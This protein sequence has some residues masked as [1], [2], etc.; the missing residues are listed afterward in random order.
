MVF[1]HFSLLLF[2]SFIFFNNTKQFWFFTHNL[3]FLLYYL[4]ILG[5]CL[6]YLPI[7]FNIRCNN[8]LER[9]IYIG[10]SFHLF[11]Y[12][13][14]YYLH[15]FRC[16]VSNTILFC[17]VFFNGNFYLIRL[18]INHGHL[19]IIL[20]ILFLSFSISNNLHHQFFNLRLS[21]IVLSL[22]LLCCI[23][24]TWGLFHNFFLFLLCFNLFTYL[25]LSFW[26]SYFSIFFSR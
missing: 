21:V 14:F 3:F 19:S 23:M 20:T 13:L 7:C 12:H 1:I 2:Y 22:L 26:Y 17:F 16:Y 6:F 11:L 8:N 15:V 4:L 18:V 9:Y 24:I 25:F 10:Y 5:L